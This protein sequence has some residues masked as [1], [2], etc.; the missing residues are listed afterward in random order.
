MTTSNNGSAPAVSS[1]AVQRYIQRSDSVMVTEAELSY[2]FQSGLCVEVVGKQYTEARLTQ[3]SGVPLVL[4]R[5]HT[6]VATVVY[7][8]GETVLFT[9]ESPTL[10]C[11][12]CGMK[13]PNADAM[14]NC[15]ECTANNWMLIDPP[16]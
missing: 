13:E 7:A 6:H 5:Q 2:R 4:L 12:H 11:Q 15:T 10:E 8:R 3:D 9:D 1:H 16:L 14:A